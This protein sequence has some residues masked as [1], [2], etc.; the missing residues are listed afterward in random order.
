MKTTFK[1]FNFLGAPVEISLWFF[2]LFLMTSVSTTIGIFLSVL[3]HEMAHAY[4][5]HRR[6]WKVFGIK[7][8]FLFGTAKLDMSMPEKDSIPVVVAGPLSNL[9]FAIFVF[10]LIDSFYMFGF[11]LDPVISQFLNTLLFI[12]IILFIFNLLPIYPLDG[13]RI[14]RDFLVLKMRNQRQMAIR[15]ASIISLIF[16]IL[17][18]IYSIFSVSILL[19][20]FS[21]LFIYTAVKELQSLKN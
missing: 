20:F 15:I 1:L 2:L 11:Y 10:I 16:S 9:I 5:A 17:L 14:V 21:A 7:L 3:I 12:N 6:G 4:I 19:I 8:D 13:G 18:L